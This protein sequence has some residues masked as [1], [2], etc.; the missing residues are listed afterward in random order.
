[1]IEPPVMRLLPSYHS[2]GVGYVVG[3]LLKMVGELT[4]PDDFHIGIG[5]HKRTYIIDGFKAERFTV[6]LSSLTILNT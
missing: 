6:G 2:W 3:L 4:L 1:M 5:S